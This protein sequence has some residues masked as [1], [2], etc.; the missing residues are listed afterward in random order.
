MWLWVAVG[1]TPR[2]PPPSSSQALVTSPAFLRYNQG[3]RLDNQGQYPSRG[4]VACPSVTQLR[5]LP[6]LT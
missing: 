3:I 4:L 6:F 5:F 2:R 1:R